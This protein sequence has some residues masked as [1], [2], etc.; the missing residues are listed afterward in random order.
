MSLRF[1]Y[2]VAVCASLFAFGCADPGGGGRRDAGPGGSDGGDG[3]AM[4][5]PDGRP[6]VSGVCTTAADCPAD[7]GI[8][9][10]GE[11]DCIEGRCL[12]VNTPTCADE[13]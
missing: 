9:C 5:A 13:A 11:I 8:M 10:N 3:G 6:D 2:T 7:D 1:A 4:D 12:A